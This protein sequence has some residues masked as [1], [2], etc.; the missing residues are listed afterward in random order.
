MA[1]T[2]S[3]L[4]R[5]AH[6]S[7]GIFT[8]QCQHTFYGHDDDVIAVVGDRT[9]DMLSRPPGTALSSFGT[10]LRPAQHTFA[11]HASGV[12]SV[13]VTPDGRHASRHLLIRH[14]GCGTLKAE[15]AELYPIRNV[16]LDNREAPGSLGR[17][18]RSNWQC[19]SLPDSFELIR[20]GK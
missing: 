14:S 3:R 8:A 17:G 18:R 13:A 20:R 5:T 15:S 19:P 1:A 2:L 10:C 16:A 11:A 9:A 4:P 7:S 6:S 12:S